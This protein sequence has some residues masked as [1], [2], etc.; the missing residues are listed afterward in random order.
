MSEFFRE[1]IDTVV[2]MLSKWIAACF[3]DKAPKKLLR[4][5]I[6]RR[7]VIIITK[8]YLLSQHLIEFNW[9]ILNVLPNTYQHCQITSTLTSPSFTFY[10]HQIE[11]VIYYKL[12]SLPILFSLFFFFCHIKN[13]SWTL[14][15]SYS[16]N[17]ELSG[18]MWNTET[19]LLYIN[20]LTMKWKIVI[21]FSPVDLLVVGNISRNE[22]KSEGNCGKAMKWENVEKCWKN[23]EKKK[24]KTKTES[25]KWQKVKTKHKIEWMLSKKTKQ[26]VLQSNETKQ[27]V[28]SM[29]NNWTQ[30]NE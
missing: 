26:R 12:T 28:Y 4:Y 24:T 30:T 8:N 11:F 29:N 7:C 22:R 16:R 13:I 1:K 21:S 25:N 2:Q 19:L 10:C 9:C 18:F 5:P 3:D 6:S 17:N 14:D 20:L 27:R 23:G 15:T